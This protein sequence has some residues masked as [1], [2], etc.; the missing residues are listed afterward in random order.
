MNKP[1]P[2]P[3]EE[4]PKPAEQSTTSQGSSQDAKG[5]NGSTGEK[6]AQTNTESDKPSAMDLD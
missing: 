6:T 1:K 2:K 3:K 5:D 4:P